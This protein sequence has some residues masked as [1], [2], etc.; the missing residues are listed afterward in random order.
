MDDQTNQV[1]ARPGDAER[2][3][4]TGAVALGRGGRKR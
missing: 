2:V 3:Q 1:G 4:E